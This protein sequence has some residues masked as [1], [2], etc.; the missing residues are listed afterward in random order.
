MPAPPGVF[1]EGNFVSEF[2]RLVTPPCPAGGGRRGLSRSP[3][4]AGCVPAGRPLRYD[5][6]AGLRGP[7]GSLLCGCYPHHHFQPALLE[8]GKY[9]APILSGPAARTDRWMALPSP[10]LSLPAWNRPF[11]FPISLRAQ[12][13]DADQGSPSFWGS[14]SI[15]TATAL[16]C[17]GLGQWGC[18]VMRLPSCARRSQPSPR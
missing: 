9:P 18:P 12:V 16:G 14:H 15:L 13:G 8:C 1:P 3:A 6:A 10:R 2:R 7:L 5:P 4:D 17:C 11:C